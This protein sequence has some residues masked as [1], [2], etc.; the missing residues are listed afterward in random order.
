ME[1]KLMIPHRLPLTARETRHNRRNNLKERVMRRKRLEDYI[2]KTRELLNDIEYLNRSRKSPRF[3]TRSRKMP[4][5]K[6]V[7]FMLYMVKESITNASER[8]FEKTGDDTTEMTEQSFSEARD[9]INWPAIAELYRMTVDLGYEGCY[10]TWHGYRVSAVDGSKIALPSDKVLKD[11][12]GAAGSGAASVTGQG[13]ILYDVY[14]KIVIDASLSPLSNG[15][16]ELAEKH[17]ERLCELKSF[18]KELIILDRGYPSF[19]FIKFLS[20]HNIAFVM[21]V[22]TKFNKDIDAQTV[23]DGTVVLKQRG[24]EDIKVRVL[25]F[26]LSSRETEMLITNLPDRRMGIKAFKTLYFKRWPVET[27]YDEIKNKIELENMSGRT[28]NSVMQDFYVSMFMTDTAAAASREAQPII[29]EQREG[30]QNKY[31]YHVNMN[32]AAGVLKDH[33]I[34][35]LFEKSPETR[36][37]KIEKIIHL[38]TKHPVPYRP[39]RSIPRNKSPRKVKFHHNQKPNC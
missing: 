34:K 22:R 1:M 11:Y 14:N 8:F 4:F 13:S 28:I 16:R 31:I 15:E 38:L 3:F 23:K 24:A 10:E 27:K 6:L 2:N 35:A 39:E 36:K 19:D 32:H 29:T 30:K 7:S 18:H 5:R 33:F 12:F 25:K 17:I 9:K 20:D 21:R 37:K 26:K